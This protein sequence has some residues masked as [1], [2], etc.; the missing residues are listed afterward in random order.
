[1]VMRG[2]ELDPLILHAD[3]ERFFR[4]YPAWGRYGVSAYSAV[5]ELEVDAICETKLERFALVVVIQRSELDRLGIEIVPTFR[6]PHVT[7]AHERLGPLVE[8]LR[9]CEHRTI[10][11]RHHRREGR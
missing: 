6:S 10:E 11:N 1:M 9:S 7:L 2:D 4:R 8:G 5:D 3:A